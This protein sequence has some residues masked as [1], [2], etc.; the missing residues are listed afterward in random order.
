M[1]RRRVS[2]AS[3]LALLAFAASAR[4]W[5]AVPRPPSGCAH[6]PNAARSRHRQPLCAAPAATLPA[7]VSLLAGS[8]GGAIGVVV[9]YPLDTLKTKTQST[10]DGG[11]S[12]PLALAAAIYREEGVAGF[13]GGMSSTMW[14]QAIIKAA[15]FFVYGACRNFLATTALGLDT[16]SLC[17]AAAS[18]GAVGAFIITPVERIKCVMQA[19]PAGSFVNPIGCVAELVRRDGVRGLLFRGLGATLLRE[20]PA[21]SFYFVTFDLSKAY[22]L[23]LM[24]RTPA[25]LLAGAFA[26]AMSWVPVYPV[27]VVKTQIQV[28]LDAGGA[29]ADGTL[30]AVTRRLWRQGGFW[31]FWDGLGP[32]L[33]RAVVNHA[34]TFL[35][36]DLICGVWL[37]RH[38]V[39]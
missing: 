10:A 15:L 28:E 26:G 3:R 23:T 37:R 27:D 12:N 7:A 39:A 9:A 8:I 1:R 34:V 25:L 33:A 13:Y 22:L 19:K 38:G 29:E 20:L 2:S 17:L 6:P 14:G 18:S 4:A 30:G 11:P 35:V 31:A 16:L 24:A 21:C 32:K 5:S 36:F